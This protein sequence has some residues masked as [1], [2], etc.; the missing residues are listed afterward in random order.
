MSMIFLSFSLLF[1]FYFSSFFLLFLSPLLSHVL[2]LCFFHC[3]SFHFLS[4]LSL[5]ICPSTFLFL[6]SFLLLLPHPILPPFL[7]SLYSPNLP[8][9]ILPSSLLHFSSFF[10][11]LLPLPSSSFNLSIFHLRFPSATPSSSCLS[12]SRNPVHLYSSSSF[13]P[14]H[15]NLTLLTLILFRSF[16][17]YKFTR[18]L[19]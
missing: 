11:S 1:S 15:I 16:T 7:L 4:F 19:F 2:P 12:F 13:L 9:L 17:S 14:V 8:S 5:L 6:S 18:L 3:P 10:P